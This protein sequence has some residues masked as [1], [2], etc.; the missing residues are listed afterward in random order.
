MIHLVYR[1]CC[2]I[3]HY[4]C[5]DYVEQ[6]YDFQLQQ[7]RKLPNPSDKKPVEK[8]DDVSET[9]STSESKTG[10]KISASDAVQ[11]FQNLLEKEK[12]RIFDLVCLF[13]M[14]LNE[15]IHT[16]CNCCNRIRERLWKKL[17]WP[18]LILIMSPLFPPVSIHPMQKTRVT[19]TP[20][21]LT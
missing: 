21:M 16:V 9:S 1:L 11:L 12:V 18:I 4:M 6:Q 17:P 10:R 20:T 13:T 19:N 7:F 15:F 8:D 2:L 14:D 5:D 3:A